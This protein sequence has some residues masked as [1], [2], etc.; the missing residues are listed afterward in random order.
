[1]SRS[2]NH[3]ERD[4][5]GKCDGGCF[6]CIAKIK[7]DAYLNPN[8]GEQLCA[9][10]Y[11]NEFDKLVRSLK[12]EERIKR[13][14]EKSNE[15]NESYEK[16]ISQS[17]SNYARTNSEKMVN[18]Y[19]KKQVTI[20]AA[21]FRDDSADTFVEIQKF[22]QDDLRVSYGDPK[23]PVI[24]IETLEGIMDASIGDYIIKG[25][26]G[27]FYPCKPDVFAKTYEEVEE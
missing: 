26:N 2:F 5:T 12:E 21:L 24:K 9:T 25:V 1:M 10:L 13:E 11:Q 17:N 22:M 23:N 6:D 14:K 7:C 15:N 8:G 16:I 3:P 27:E 18:K 4:R 20:E 19:R